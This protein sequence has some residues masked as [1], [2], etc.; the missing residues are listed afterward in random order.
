MFQFVLTSSCIRFEFGPTDIRVLLNI[1]ISQH[2]NTIT[3]ICIM[4]LNFDNRVLNS[5]EE[6][7]KKQELRRFLNKLSCFNFNPD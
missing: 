4:E 6:M 2:D 1:C 3:F 7:K 5:N